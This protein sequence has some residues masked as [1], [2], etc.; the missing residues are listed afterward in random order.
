MERKK[1]LR[2]NAKIIRNSL[3][4]EQI[5]NSIIDKIIEWKIFEN[6]KN[7]MIFYP[8]QNEIS[9]LKLTKNTKKNFYFPTIVNGEII[10]KMYKNED[11]FVNGKYN[12][13]EPTGE[14]LNKPDI[15][16]LIFLPALSADLF[17]HRL[18]YGKG[19]Y[20]KF[21]P[22]LAT[23]TVK[24]I[25]IP[26]ALLTEKLLTETHDQPADYIVTENV[27]LMSKNYFK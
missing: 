10:A 25:P 4:I 26:Q 15:I 9:L 3:N 27:I 13:P 14:N 12:I 2:Q 8:I 7:I 23:K 17:G 6:A 5:S 20:D 19:F 18:G 11:H 16:D 21:I 24:I 1:L 22:K